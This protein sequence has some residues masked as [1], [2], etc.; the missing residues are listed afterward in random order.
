ML[1]FGSME[2]PNNSGFGG[3]SKSKAPSTPLEA[4]SGK[5]NKSQIAEFFIPH[6]TPRANAIRSW[7]HTYCTNPTTG[8]RFMQ[9][10]PDKSGLNPPQPSPWTNVHKDSDANA[11]KLTISPYDAVRITRDQ[12]GRCPDVSSVTWRDWNGNIITEDNV[13]FLDMD[14]LPDTAFPDGV[15]PT[16]AL[17]SQQ[18]ATPQQQPAFVHTGFAPTMQAQMTPQLMSSP[19]GVPMHQHA[20]HHAQQPLA[21]AA[22]SPPQMQAASAA[23]PPLPQPGQCNIPHSGGPVGANMAS[24]MYH[25]APPL[26]PNA[27]QPNYTPF[28]SMTQPSSQSAP[29]SVVEQL[30]MRPQTAV[31]CIPSSVYAASQPMPPKPQPGPG[32][33]GASGPPAQPLPPLQ[34]MANTLGSM[35][36]HLDTLGVNFSRDLRDLQTSIGTQ[37]EAKIDAAAD[38]CIG[39]INTTAAKMYAA[40]SR[41]GSTFTLSLARACAHAV[42]AALAH[43][44]QRDQIAGRDRCCRRQRWRRH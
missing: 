25:G 17:Q 2:P 22:T 8:Q 36:T 15:Q 30:A 4:V 5:L 20:Q 29:G 32:F 6:N 1:G 35:Q 18:L 40:S 3:V 16:Y 9:F 39:V 23:P 27:Q 24:G 12:L 34:Q 37:M 19:G 33:D 21:A 26:L 31:T 38:K 7:C 10:R 43:C 44:V 11:P 42:L 41:H 13:P 28:S 14:Q